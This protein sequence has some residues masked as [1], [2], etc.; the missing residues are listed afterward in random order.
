MYKWQT[1]SNQY[2]VAFQYLHSQSRFSDRFYKSVKS[3]K[4][5]NQVWFGVDWPAGCLYNLK[6]NRS[7]IN[8]IEC[9]LQHMMQCKQMNGIRNS[10][11]E[12]AM[13]RIL[14]LNTSYKSYRVDLFDC[15]VFAINQSQ[16][17]FF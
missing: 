16:W 17:T 2:N 4:K 14:K 15:L 12:I 11:A 6:M 3:K 5:R 10:I 9:L 13:Y 8:F 1:I 7:T